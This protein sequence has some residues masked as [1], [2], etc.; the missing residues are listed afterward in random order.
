VKLSSRLVLAIA[1]NGV[2]GG[3]NAEVYTAVPFTTRKL[4]IYPVKASA[5]VTPLYVPT[6]NDI[7]EVGYTVVVEVPAEMPFI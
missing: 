6:F 7:A 1:V 3:V 2:V 4:D 5:L